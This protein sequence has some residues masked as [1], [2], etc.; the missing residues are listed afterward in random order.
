MPAL[1]LW[2][3]ETYLGKIIFTLLSS[4]LP[5]LE[6]RGG[7]PIGVALG[8]PIPVAFLAALVGNMIPVPFI[9][10][11]ARKMLK[12]IRKTFPKLNALVY[13]I[14]ARA[15]AKSEKV[16]KYQ[17]W[18]LLILV[19]I[20]LPGTGAWTGS[21]VAAFLDMRMKKAIPAIFMGVVIAG[22]IT[23]MVTYGAVALF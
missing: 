11:F 8:L 22:I 19:A 12:W 3:H 13:K 18:G 2:L 4:M 7:V 17:F 6:L 21:L 15:H 20:P 14:E 9:L 16:V 23:T 1:S 10:L 5:V